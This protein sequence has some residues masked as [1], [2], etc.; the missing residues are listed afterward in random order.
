MTVRWKPLLILSGVFAFIAVVGVVAITYAIK[1]RGSAG[2]L[3][4]ARALRAATR[5]ASM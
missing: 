3:R 4:D 2:M 1:P 5:L